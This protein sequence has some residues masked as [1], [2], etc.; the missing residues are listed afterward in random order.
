MLRKLQ[1][2]STM[3]C[4]LVKQR[5]LVH[6]ERLASAL[7]ASTYANYPT[8][9][10]R[11]ELTSNLYP[12]SNPCFIC[13]QSNANRAKGTTLEVERQQLYLNVRKKLNKTKPLLKAIKI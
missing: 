6:R 2:I 9:S 3:R 11:S 4:Q 7:G 12:V 10:Q 1:S 13:N 5:L 8:Q